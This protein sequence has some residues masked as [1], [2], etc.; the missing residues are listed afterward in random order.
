MGV[1]KAKQILKFIFFKNLFFFQK[2]R[3]KKIITLS[4]LGPSASVLYVVAYM[5]KPF[6]KTSQP[7]FLVFT[8]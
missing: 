2:S 1:T 8:I 7:F 3:L 6:V 4:T 5:K